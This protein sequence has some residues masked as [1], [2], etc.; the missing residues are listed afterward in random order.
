MLPPRMLT[1][2]PVPVSDETT[3]LPALTCPLQPAPTCTTVDVHEAAT[4]DA[5]R[6]PK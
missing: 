4:R 6:R 5:D 1:D 2:T 3:R